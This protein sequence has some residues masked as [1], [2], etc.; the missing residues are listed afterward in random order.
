MLQK[1]TQCSL[2]P[3]D[4]SITTGRTLTST[5]AGISSIDQRNYPG[6]ISTIR[7]SRLARFFDYHNHVQSPHIDTAG[8]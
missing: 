3:D 6:P 2:L 5:I 4:T 1:Y 7:P 8:L